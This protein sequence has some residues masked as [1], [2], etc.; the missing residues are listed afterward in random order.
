MSFCGQFGYICGHYVSI[1][2]SFSH[3]GL[4]WC[5]FEVIVSL[6]SVFLIYFSHMSQIARLGFFCSFIRLLVRLLLPLLVLLCLGGF[7]GK[8]VK[9]LN[10]CPH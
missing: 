1:C 9:H 7:G 4:L 2:V 3:L 10:I 5:L 8:R 6:I